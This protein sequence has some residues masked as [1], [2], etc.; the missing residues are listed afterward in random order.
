MTNVQVSDTFQARVMTW[1]CARATAASYLWDYFE[2]LDP[3]VAVLQEV[4][5]IPPTIAQKYDVRTRREVNKEGKEQ[6]TSSALLV[7]GTIG[8]KV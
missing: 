2:E 6:R 1:N 5:S 8:N 7:R 4:S 3:D